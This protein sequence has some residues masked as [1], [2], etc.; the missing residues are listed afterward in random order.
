VACFLLG[1]ACALPLFAAAGWPLAALGIFGILFAVAY[2]LFRN[3]FFVGETLVGIS[4]GT[5][6]MQGAFLVQA[7]RFSG[8]VTVFSIP[9]SLLV[10]LIL[11]VNEIPDA[12]A[13][14]ASGKYTLAVRLGSRR[15]AWLA[16]LGIVVVFASVAW[17]ALSRRLPFAWLAFLAV[18]VAAVAVRRLLACHDRPQRLRFVHPAFVLV[19]AVVCLALLVAL[20]EETA[21]PAALPLVVLSGVLLLLFVPPLWKARRA[22]EAG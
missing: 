3:A 20:L 9:V 18:P 22:V 19:H 11:L 10:A 8:E 7:G 4:F 1:T 17:L 21:A 5:L 12:A 13:D 14:R 2:S 6:V 16:C 15:T